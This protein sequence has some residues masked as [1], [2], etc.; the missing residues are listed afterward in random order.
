MPPFCAGWWR[1]ST[2]GTPSLVQAHGRWRTARLS[3]QGWRGRP[4]LGE[5]AQ[6][7]GHHHALAHLQGQLLV[8]ARGWQT[9]V[10]SAWRASARSASLAPLSTASTPGAVLAGIVAHGFDGSGTTFHWGTQ[11]RAHLPPNKVVGQVRVLVTLPKWVTVSDDSAAPPACQSRP[12]PSCALSATGARPFVVE[13]RG[14]V[15]RRLGQL[16]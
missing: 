9:P 5:G 16:G 1:S 13:L 12:A 3:A 11:G 7:L 2:C 10:S 15:V 8:K 4:L 14:G 6:A